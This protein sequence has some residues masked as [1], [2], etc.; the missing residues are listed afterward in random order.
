MTEVLPRGRAGNAQ[1]ECGLCR[2]A[3]KPHSSLGEHWEWQ[4]F[5]KS[6]L[7]ITISHQQTPCV[8]TPWLLRSS[9]SLWLGLGLIMN[10][11]LQ[12]GFFHLKEAWVLHCALHEPPVQPW[13]PLTG[14]GESPPCAA[15]AD[16]RL[17]HLHISNLDPSSLALPDAVSLLQET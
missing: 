4:G 16:L 2:A 15:P 6:S 14:S 9:C 1:S 17:P 12:E 8:L 10:P 11:R 13:A 3:L 5:V 7:E